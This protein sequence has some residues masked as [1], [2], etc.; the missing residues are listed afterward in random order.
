[1]M[2]KHPVIGFDIIN[3]IPAFTQHAKIIRHHHE[4]IDGKG[5]PDGLRGD[6]IPVEARILALADTYDALTTTRPYRKAKPKNKALSIMKEVA[7]SQLDEELV[8]AFLK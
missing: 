1:M 7:G 8:A 5:Y 6:N 4:R 2:Q 3:S